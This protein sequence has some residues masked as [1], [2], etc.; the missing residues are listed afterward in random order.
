MPVRDVVRCS[1]I[2]SD[3]DHNFFDDDDTKMISLSVATFTFV[4][5]LSRLRLNTPPSVLYVSWMPSSLSF[6]VS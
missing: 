3:D 1:S 2:V 5:A 6:E 4:F